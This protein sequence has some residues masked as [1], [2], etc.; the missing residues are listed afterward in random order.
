MAAFSRVPPTAR[1]QIFSHLKAHNGKSIALSGQII[2]SGVNFQGMSGE[3][4]ETLGPI[5]N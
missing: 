2:L 4:L 1:L 5:F 3:E